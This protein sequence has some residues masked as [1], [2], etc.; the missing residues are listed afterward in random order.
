GS[1]SKSLFP[2]LRI[3]FI[4][5]NQQVENEMGV[6]VPLVDE[7][8][9]VKALLTNNTPAISQAI[10]GGIL[11]HLECSLS[12]WNRPK[13][14][15]YKKKRDQMIASLNKYIGRYRYDWAGNISWNEPDGGFFIKMSLPIEADSASVLECAARYNVI[16]CPMRYF[17][18]NG[19]GEREIR[20]TFSNLSL[21][22]IDAGVSSLAAYLKAKVTTAVNERLS[23][24]TSLSGITL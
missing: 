6:T 18:L 2:G 8:V 4:C 7:M 12:E 16:F 19:G 9:K 14:G 22:Q 10:L 21:E 1:F 13:F 15:T 23:H 24:E 17:Y 11:L 20:L 3:G 5:A